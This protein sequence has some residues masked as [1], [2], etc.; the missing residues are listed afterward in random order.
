MQ[1]ASEL[2]LRA[3]ERRESQLAF[4]GKREARDRETRERGNLP[5]EGGP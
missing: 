5:W 2:A 1:L 3:R 4:G